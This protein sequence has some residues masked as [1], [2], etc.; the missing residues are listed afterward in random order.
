MTVT[1][2][3]IEFDRIDYDREADVL[4]LSAGDPSLATSFDE[5]PDGHAVRF[6]A[7]GRLVG[8]T[9]VG[10]RQVAEEG[11]DVLLHAPITLTADAIASMVR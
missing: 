8:V 10:A 9:V 4:Y 7:E 3:A 2:A 6:D 1:I 11:R 5:T